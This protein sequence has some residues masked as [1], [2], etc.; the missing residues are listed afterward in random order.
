MSSANDKIADGIQ[1]HSID[2]E[3]FSVDL[4]NRVLPILNRVERQLVAEIAEIDPTGGRTDDSRK[5]RKE[6]L[7]KQ[8]RGT[9]ATGYDSIKKTVGD[10][11]QDIAKLSDTAGRKIVNDA[12]GVEIM[13]VSIAPEQLRALADGTMIQGAVVKEHWDRQSEDLRRKF[14]D[15]IQDGFIRGE[16][17]T[18]IVNRVRGTKAR[19]YADGIM[20]VSKNNAGAL[21]RTSVQAV[22]NSARLEVFKSNSDT[23]MATQWLSTLDNRTCLVRGTL[24]QTPSGF[25]RIDDIKTGDIVIGGSGKKRRVL[26]TPRSQ[27]DALMKITMDNGQTII[28]TPDH[29]FLVEVNGEQVWRDAINLFNGDEISRI[30][31]DLAG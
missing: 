19:G 3:R 17:S 24:L 25:Q 9:I 10:D 5:A 4:Q 26:A 29:R 18:E 23:I 14:Q 30:I 12:I 6:A 8:T 16:P 21:V 27:T 15:R 7:L 13:T 22:A 31:K 28:C 1:A 2:L 20:N 11:L